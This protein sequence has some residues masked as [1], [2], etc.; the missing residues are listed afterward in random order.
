MS[1]RP[2][3]PRSHRFSS[4]LA[5]VALTAVPLTVVVALPQSASAATPV[6]ANTTGSSI[7]PVGSLVVNVEKVVYGVL[8]DV[9]QIVSSVPNPGLCG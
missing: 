4:Y 9:S 7:D 5:T 1:P 2:N 8:C 6:H 3:R